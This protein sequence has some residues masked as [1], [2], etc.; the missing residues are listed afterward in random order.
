MNKENPWTIQPW[1]IRC[2][3]RKAGIHVP[4][5]AIK[6]PDK[7]ISGPD[8]SLEN[9]DFL[10]TV[11]V[12]GLE[13]ANVRCRIHHWS[14]NPSNRMP[15]VKYPCSLKTEPIFEEDAP[16]LDKLRLIPLPKEKSDV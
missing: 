4:E 6:M 11:T 14:T 10:I 1:H 9:R 5:Y 15:Y 7:P 12:N 13:K 8:F 16:I 3:F 2:S